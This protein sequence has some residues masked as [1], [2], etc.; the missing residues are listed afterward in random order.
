MPV[1]HKDII[2]FE[3]L[4]SIYSDGRIFSKPKPLSRGNKFIGL[5]PSKG[6][7]YVNVV[8]IK[9]NKKYLMSVHTLVATHFIPNPN[10]KP[11]VN[12]KDG[13][14]SNNDVN[15]LEWCTASENTQHAFDTKL[16][17][18]DHRIHDVVRTISMNTAREIRHIRETKKYTYKKLAEM[19]NVS[20]DTVGDIVRGET[21][22]EK[23][24]VNT[25]THEVMEHERCSDTRS[26]KS[27]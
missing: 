7:W 3:D 8:L 23:W 11:Q 24:E 27:E 10:D 13:D 21:Y 14:K 22:K 18:R 15:N 20:S 26:L 25:P 6:N 5:K 2:G 4:Y 16:C 9:N 19:F 17:T 12:H 1:A